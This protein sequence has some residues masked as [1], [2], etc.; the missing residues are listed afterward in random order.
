MHSAHKRV[1]CAESTQASQKNLNTWKDSRDNQLIR[2]G[3]DLKMNCVIL[4][5]RVA[6]VGKQFLYVIGFQ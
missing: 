2:M 6:F 3:C 4:F 5:C 1:T